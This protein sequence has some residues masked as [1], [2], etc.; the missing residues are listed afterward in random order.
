MQSTSIPRSR[1]ARFFGRSP[2]SAEATPWYLGAL[3]ELTVGRV[4]DSL[5]PGWHTIHAVPIGRRGSDIDHLAIGPSGVFTI[6]TKHHAGKVWIASRTLMVNGQRTSHL[7]NAVH[8]ASRAAKLLGAAAGGPVFVT[9]I[10]AIVGARTLTIREHPDDVVVARA[11]RLVRALQRRP[12]VLSPEE[13]A[14]LA[15]LAADPATWRSTEPAVPDLAAFAELRESVTSAHRIRTAWA[16]GGIIAVIAA[17]FA[18]MAGF[19]LLI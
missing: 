13:V 6:N 7:R 3:G 10:I 15:G 19:G 1:L 4:L 11:E 9:P 5:G 18:A 2:L 8:E 17:P 14:E 16:F 12:P